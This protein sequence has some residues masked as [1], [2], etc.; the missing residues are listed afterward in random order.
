MPF[1]LSFAT[2]D[3]CAADVVSAGAVAVE[4]AAVESTSAGV[5]VST[6]VS[7]AGCS[8]GFELQAA[9]AKERTIAAAKSLNVFFIRDKNLPSYRILQRV[10]Q[11]KNIFFSFLIWVTFTP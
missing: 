10:T 5:S 9:I 8:A 3:Y 2:D 4:S 7:V 6:G 11:Q 1:L